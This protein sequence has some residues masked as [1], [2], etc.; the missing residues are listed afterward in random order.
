MADQPSASIL[1]PTLR[2]AD[3][4]SV[5][6]DSVVPQ[7]EA[8]DAEVIVISDGPDAQVG[9]VAGRFPVGLV[10]LPERQGLNE[11]RNA[12]IRAARADLLV[13][14]DADVDAP[15]GWLNGLLDGVRADPDIEVFGGPIRG[16]LASALFAQ[17]KGPLPCILAHEQW[18]MAGVPLRP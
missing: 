13:L 7:A 18:G 3:Y 4:L 15:Q 11:A 17:H 8:L 10:T 1:I 12:G 14:I 5:A 16:R 9:E 2:S 6:L